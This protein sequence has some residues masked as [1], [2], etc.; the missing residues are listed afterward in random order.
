MPTL[1][2]AIEIAISA[3]QT[4]TDKSGAPY[5]MHV[6]R[7]NMDITRLLQITE[8]DRKRLNKYLRAYN[9]LLQI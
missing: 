6:I 8:Q 4:Q 9:R 1:Q 2:K 3:H 7:D 5:I